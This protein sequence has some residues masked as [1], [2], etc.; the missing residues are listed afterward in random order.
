MIEKEAILKLKRWAKGKKAPP[1]RV[2]I[3]PTNK[4]NLKC[5]FC[6]QRLHPYDYSKDL[7]QKR[8]L[9][10]TKELCEMGVDI[11]QISGGGEPL[12]TPQTTI[13]MMRII[14]SY[15]VSG[16][17]VN[18]GTLWKES[19]V[20]DVVRIGWDNVIFSVDGPNP[21]INDISRGVPGT[22]KKIIKSIKLFN[23]Y[24]RKFKREKPFF[25]FST[26][27]SIFNYKKL[28]EIIK[29][30]SKLGIHNVTFEPVFVSNPTVEKLKLTKRQRAWLM[31]KIPEWKEL[32][33]SL[34][35]NT[36]LD[37]LVEVK[38]IE[39]TGNLKKKILEKV[40]KRKTKNK[41]LNLP[42]YEPWLWP[43]IE[44]DGRVG[45][46]STIFLED[47][48]GYEVSVRNRSFEDVWYGEEFN[49]FRKSIMENKLMDACANCVSTHLALNE[50]IRKKMISEKIE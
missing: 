22:F 20:R 24:K 10:L 46:C 34:G 13:T 1:H 15:G 6:F 38:E 40:E 27:V 18:N 26:V 31:E 25:E 39:K 4:C 19:Y 45:P 28:G 37:C 14:K 42:C 35:V 9:A 21:E 5:P 11:L 16:R 30:A 47:F 8:W 7:P 17:L 29:L 49:A 43:K 2:L 12:M 32:A 3:Y 41:F 44:A 23:L 33:E 36:N 48:V 50:E